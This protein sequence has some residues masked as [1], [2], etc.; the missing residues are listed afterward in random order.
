MKLEFCRSQGGTT[1]TT[2]VRLLNRS[3]SVVHSA[4]PEKLVTVSVVVVRG[5]A[6]SRPTIC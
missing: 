4:T 6:S 5:R 1:S 2:D 3:Y